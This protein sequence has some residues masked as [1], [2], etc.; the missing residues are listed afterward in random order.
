MNIYNPSLRNLYLN[1]PQNVFTSIY[2]I[3]YFPKTHNFAGELKFGN[4]T[5]IRD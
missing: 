5:K 1:F 2:E 3:R 4:T